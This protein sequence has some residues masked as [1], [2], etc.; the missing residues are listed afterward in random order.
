ME[1]Q[2]HTAVKTPAFW[3]GTL[4]IFTA[5]LSASLRSA[6]ATDIKVAYLDPV[7][8]ADS[9]RMIGT[10]LGSAFLGFSIMLLVSSLLLDRIGMKR[11]LLAASAAFIVGT[12]IVIFAGEVSSGRSIYH[13]IVAGMFICGLGW[14]CVEGT[15]NPM[16]A[17][18]Y[19]QNTTHWMNMLHA[20]WPM[21]M[22]VGGLTG[23][24]ASQLGIDWRI[25]F[26]VVG[27]FALV[28][29]VWTSRLEFP[30]TTSVRMNVASRGQLA[31]LL[32][33]PSFFIWFVLMLLTAATELAPGQW[34]DVALTS[35][36][37]MRGVLLLVYVS[38]IMF[39]ARHFAGPLAHKL[40]AEGLL[41]GSSALAFLG[42][43]SLSM[44]NSPLTA[45][46]AATA[47]GL[48]VCYLWPTMIAVVAERYPRGGALAIG[49]MGVAGSISTYAV[50]PLLG[51]V[52]DNAKVEAAGGAARLATLSGEQ[53]QPVLVHAASE[54]FRLVSAIPAF[55]VLAF[56]AFR[57][58]NR[59]RP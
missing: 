48:G 49:L 8:I 32:Q 3:V 4:A 1:V 55:L 59:T 33:R 40:S 43:L 25:T 44:A 2:P 36:V 35:V 41:A 15:V 14:G 16:V 11:M 26:S 23:V 37:G 56:L 51:S 38:A 7:S 31:E 58:F 12:A 19:P 46:L 24:G 54:S 5:G 50:L 9:G 53:L 45:M 27:L 20:W 21:G 47:W 13:V 29:A 39:V 42:L 18:L 30:P 28:L 10:A 6:I 34:V 17:S 22:I 52:Y 57:F